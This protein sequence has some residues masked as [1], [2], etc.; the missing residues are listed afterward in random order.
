M[1]QGDVTEVCRRSIS[2]TARADVV[3]NTDSSVTIN[4]QQ[5]IYDNLRVGMRAE[6]AI[7]K[8]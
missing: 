4:V 5:L 8:V 2:F 3:Y 1:G 7:G 6:V